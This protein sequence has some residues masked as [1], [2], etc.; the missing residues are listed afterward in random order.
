MHFE[1]A[2]VFLRAFL[3]PPPPPYLKIKPSKLV[4]SNFSI[5]SIS[6]VIIEMKDLKYYEISF[7]IVQRELCPTGTM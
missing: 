7:F 5:C 6:A 2:S 3:N 4:L 1:I